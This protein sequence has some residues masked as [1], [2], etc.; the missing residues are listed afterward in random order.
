LAKEE[1]NA[2]LIAELESN[3]DRYRSGM[4]LRYN[5]TPE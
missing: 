5:L 4:P 3:I 2:P 1:R